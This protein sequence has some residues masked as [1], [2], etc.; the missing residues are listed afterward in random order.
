VRSIKCNLSKVRVSRP[1]L[2]AFLSCRVHGKENL[3]YKLKQIMINKVRERLLLG[4]NI[5]AGRM[6][7]DCLF[8]GVRRFSFHEC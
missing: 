7:S 2:T 4:L 5:G 8:C 1:R 3:T 6:A